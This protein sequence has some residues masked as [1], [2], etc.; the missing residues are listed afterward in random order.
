MSLFSYLYIIGV[1]GVLILR[2]TDSLSVSVSNHSLF[3][4]L[5]AWGS[6][7]ATPSN[8]VSHTP[9]YS[10]TIDGVLRGLVSNHITAH[11]RSSSRSPKLKTMD[12]GGATRGAGGVLGACS[13]SP[14]VTMALTLFVF[15]SNSLWGIEY[16]GGRLVLTALYTRAAAKSL[17]S[18]CQ[19]S[20]R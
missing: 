7:P 16:R 1:S 4:L 2:F 17:E 12:L 10:R 6:S 3:D 18:Y 13:Q 20:A 5:Y 14:P 9:W 8:G 11:H 19:A 15:V